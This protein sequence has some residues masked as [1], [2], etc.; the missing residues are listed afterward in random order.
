MLQRLI[1]TGCLSGAIAGVIL[2]I[3]HLTMVQPL[4]AK[5]EIFELRSDVSSFGIK[6]MH[7]NSITHTHTGGNVPHFHERNFHIHGNGN[8]HTHPNS[9]NEH[10]HEGPMTGVSH[11]HGA[12]SH[13]ENAW[14]PQ[15]GVERSLYSLAANML[16][17]IAFGLLLASGFTLYGRQ[18]NLFKGLV[19]AGAGF[20]CFSFLPGLGLPPEL[21]GS[22]AGDLLA[23]QIWWLATATSSVVGL[24]LFAFGKSVTWRVTSLL[25][26]TVPHA[27]GA[28]FPEFGIVGVLPPE[29]AAQFVMVTLLVSGLMWLTLGVSA[30]LL[31][32]KLSGESNSNTLKPQLN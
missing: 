16:T 8:M 18:I 3:A 17:A 19:W 4:I 6:H 24:A 5:A 30:T 26:L 21:P 1:F 14:I 27:V 28:P 23:R 20:L 7:Q 32:A 25:F 2:T 11:D 22:V 12:H 29:L 31:H 10:R 13:N 15:D 9:T